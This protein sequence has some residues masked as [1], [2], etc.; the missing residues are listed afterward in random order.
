MS[1]Q[2]TKKNLIL[3]VIIFLLILVMLYSGFQVL[4]SAFHRGGETPATTSSHKTLTVDGAEYYPRQDI[5]VF[6]LMGIDRTGPVEAVNYHRNEGSADMIALAIFDQTNETYTVLMLNRD[7]MLD[8]PV[9][10]VGGKTAGY[11]HEQLALAHTY[12]SGVEDSC[13]N[14][15]RAVSELLRGIT[16]DYYISI[17]MDAIALLN[18]AVG[19]VSVT[20][21]DDFSA[22]NSTIPKGEVLLNGQQALDFVQNRKDVGSQMNV[23]RMERHEEY[24]RGFLQSLN[25]KLKKDDTFILSTYDSVA[26]YMVSD[27][28]VNTLNSL[29]NRYSQFEL[30]DV[31]TLEGNNVKGDTY[32]EFYPDPD[33]LKQ[34]T[35]QLFYSSK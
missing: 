1:K 34:L 27:C 17:N 3:I 7:T 25:Q 16:V 10:G 33:A 31:I 32:M 18:D 14:T 11:A 12:G 2:K 26:P 20:V 4:D 29:V 9:I 28:P 19:G 6:M 22:V 24:M 13:E 23:S 5:T 35:I 21:T 30:Q 8:V 15:V